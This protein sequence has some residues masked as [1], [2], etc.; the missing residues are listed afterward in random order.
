MEKIATHNALNLVKLCVGADTVEDLAEWQASVT[1][2]RRQ[3]GLDDRPRHTT[4]MWP[5]REAEILP[6]GSLYWV[7]KG[8]I[9]VRQTIVAFEENCGED[10]I[11]R[12]DIV[13]DP[14]LVRT[15]TR[16]RSAFQGWRYLKGADAPRDL[17]R[18]RGRLA[19]ETVSLPI[20]LEHELSV[21]G[22][23]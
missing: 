15:E 7:V 5:R 3:A 8:L 9:L 21:L 12:C 23:V 18:G 10:G 16:R 6:A 14:E 1:A 11:R 20:A 2:R 13:L 22:V 17:G 19:G 4:R